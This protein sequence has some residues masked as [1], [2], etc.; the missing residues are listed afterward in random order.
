MSEIPLYTW[1]SN[2]EYDAAHVDVGD[3]GP[4]KMNGVHL[5]TSERHGNNLNRFRDLNPKTR[6]RIRS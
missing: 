2:A 4:A 5:A 3:A 6:T 1:T